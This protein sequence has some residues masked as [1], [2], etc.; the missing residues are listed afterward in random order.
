[1]RAKASYPALNLRLD[2]VAS[3]LVAAAASTHVPTPVTAITP[4]TSPPP[5]AVGTPYGHPARLPLAHAYHHVHDPDRDTSDPDSQIRRDTSRDLVVTNLRW[6]VLPAPGLQV[7]APV[8]IPA[9]TLEVPA[10]S[11]TLPPAAPAVSHPRAR[12]ANAVSLGAASAPCPCRVPIPDL[13]REPPMRSRSSLLPPASAVR[14]SPSGSRQRGLVRC[15]LSLPRLPS[16]PLGV[17]AAHA[18]SLGAASIPATGIC[19]APNASHQC[20][21]A[22]SC[23]L[24]PRSPVARLAPS[25]SRQC[26]LARRRFHPPHL[27]FAQPRAG[28]ANAVLLGAAS[29]P[30]LPFAPP[31]ARAAYAVALGAA[32]T[33]CPPFAQSRARAANAVALGVASPPRPLS[34]IAE[35]EPPTRSRSLYLPPFALTCRLSSPEREPQMRSR[36]AQSPLPFGQPRARAGVVWLGVSAAPTRSPPLH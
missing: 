21:R 6:Q 28:A 32:S 18:V 13:E 10:R 24:P 17:R 19:S 35:R 31:R 7:S 30:R 3:M 1:M 4:K 22:R 34:P 36:S 27:P 20:G 29:T 11:A 16:A 14:P 23:F 9:P 15:G 33:P 12:A 2:A 26:G 5:T 25:G 8:L